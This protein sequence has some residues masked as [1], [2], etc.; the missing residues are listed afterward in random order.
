MIQRNQKRNKRATLPSAWT[1]AESEDLQNDSRDSRTL[2]QT[3]KAQEII[4]KETHDCRHNIIFGNEGERK[5]KKANVVPPRTGNVR[6][7]D[8]GELDMGFVQ[9]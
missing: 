7:S 3:A 4:R 9:V 2:P 1:G 5:W 6:F 8:L